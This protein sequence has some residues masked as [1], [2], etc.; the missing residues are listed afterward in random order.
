M[1]A[2][3]CTDA[4]IANWVAHF[5]VPATVTTDR[6]TKFTSAL[7]SSTCT[8]L[9]IKYMFTTAYHP[10]SY[11]MV[12]CMLRQIKD[13]RRACGAGPAQ[14]SHL[15]LVLIGLHTAPKEDTVV[16]SAELVTGSHPSSSLDNCCTCQILHIST[17]LHHIHSQ[18]PMQWPTIHCRLT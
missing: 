15:P 17:C 10:L 8:R 16:P 9:D 12:E 14:H 2:S 18:L 13:A 11:R 3:T 6:G 5:G 7:W 1:A 4:F